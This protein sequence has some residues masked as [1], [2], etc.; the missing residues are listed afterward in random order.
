MIRSRSI[1][2]LLYSIPLTPYYAV[3]LLIVAA[4]FLPKDSSPIHRCLLSLERGEFELR[5]EATRTEE[6]NEGRQPHDVLGDQWSYRLSWVSRRG[7]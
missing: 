5:A 7:D 3:F 4:L 6:T 2:N 1:E